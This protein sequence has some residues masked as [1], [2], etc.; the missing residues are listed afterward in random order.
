[1]HPCLAEIR[2]ACRVA[3]NVRTNALEL[4]APYVFQ[5]LPF[6]RS[7]GRL[8]EINGDLKS[9]PDLFANV[10]RHGDTVFNSYAINRNEGHDV[11]SAHP[12][13][14]SLVLVQINQLGGLTD[15][16]DRSLLNRLPLPDESD[17]A[18][19]VISVHLAIEQKN[20]VHLH[21]LDD[22]VYFGFVAAFRKIG[23]TF[24]QS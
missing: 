7:C 6:R 9:F 3:R 11:G 19:I 1:V 5:I 20:A 23:N 15:A 18:A 13:M 16:P 21:G 12:G 10:T 4:P 14:R 2:L 8:I 24:D 17:D 22:R